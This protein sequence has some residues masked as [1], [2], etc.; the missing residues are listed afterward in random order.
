MSNQNLNQIVS[1]ERYSPFA[2][3]STTTSRTW[4]TCCI[5]QTPE[6]ERLQ[7]PWLPN[8]NYLLTMIKRLQ[9]IC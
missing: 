9:I 2:S 6:R 8:E 5:R 4:P 3:A 1:A 7:P